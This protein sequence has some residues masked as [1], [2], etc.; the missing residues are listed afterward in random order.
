[1]YNKVQYTKLNQKLFSF[2]RI[3]ILIMVLSDALIR[4][5]IKTP[6][7]KAKLDEARLTE[8]RLNALCNNENKN[9]ILGEYA[10]MHHP[11]LYDLIYSR[12]AM[13]AVPFLSVD[14]GTIY[15]H[16]SKIFNTLE[17]K[18]ISYYFEDIEELYDFVGY[19]QECYLPEKGQKGIA[20]GEFYKEV[21]M[22][23]ALYRPNTKILIDYA[24]GG[25]TEN[26]PYVSMVRLNKI[27]DYAESA[28]GALY[29]ITKENYK[30]NEPTLNK[31]YDYELYHIYDSEKYA[32]Y[33]KKGSAI[34]LV[35]TTTH[36]FG[37]T[38]VWSVSGYNQDSTDYTIKKSQLVDSLHRI[39]NY[40]LVENCYNH[41]HW[42]KGSPPSI[43]ITA[44]CDYIEPNFNIRCQGKGY[45]EVDLNNPAIRNGLRSDHIFFTR[46]GVQSI[47]CPRCEAR[48]KEK[49]TLGKEIS[50]AYS[51]IFPRNLPPN[52]KILE[53]LK[54]SLGF[55]PTNTDYLEFGKKWL[56]SEKAAIVAEI[57]GEGFN[58]AQSKEAFNKEQLNLST[59]DKQSNLSVF[60][61]KIEKLQKNVESTIAKGRYMTYQ[62]MTIYYGRGYFLK[63]STEYQAELTYLV[64]NSGDVFS[65]VQRINEVQKARNSSDYIMQE[66]G[67]LVTAVVPFVDLPIE[68]VLINKAVLVTNTTQDLQFIVRVNAVNWV[69][70]FLMIYRENLFATGS[71][72][73]LKKR[74][75]DFLYSKAYEIQQNN[76]QFLYS[77]Y[78]GSKEQIEQ[79]N[80]GDNGGNN[81]NNQPN[82]NPNSGEL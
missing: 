60:A 75:Q 63:D 34:D 13:T 2:L 67:K 33:K 77:K 31:T 30:D 62:T 57:C 27:H 81:G 25:N 48:K 45:I 4:K 11:D 41:Y 17:G 26:L 19:L 18:D 22:K 53:V 54:N 76:I 10:A 20:S 56:I 1:M 74:L 37:Y 29:L 15:G 61:S 44:D 14:S 21:L 36:S 6:S 51:H 12:F 82:G 47:P 46:S 73:T 40:T 69:Q 79:G 52:E 43:G 9:I 23:E 59:D 72:K 35:S 70:E 16:F 5:L 42:Q 50:I 66:M 3:F 24:E 65:I 32:V 55:I 64:Q 58:Q 80:S 68:K 8:L 28:N 71:L 7:N 78:N 39:W 49:A 38:P